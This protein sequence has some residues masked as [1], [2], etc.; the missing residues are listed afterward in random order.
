SRPLAPR[1]TPDPRNPKNV[2][3]GPFHLE[4]KRLHTPSSQTR[5]EMSRTRAPIRERARRQAPR[6]GPPPS[7]QREGAPPTPQ[8]L[9]DFP[10][11]GGRRRPG[12]TSPAPPP[13]RGGA[14]G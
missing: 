1:R 14:H 5:L 2:R 4:G 11:S 3:V 6:R 10:A 9:R 13:H 8:R 7:D 12:I